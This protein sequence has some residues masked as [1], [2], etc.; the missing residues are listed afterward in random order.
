M[1]F[2]KMSK[3]SFKTIFNACHQI[4]FQK[5]SKMLILGPKNDQFPSF[6]A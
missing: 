4:Q 2:L 1:N 6:W 5:K 3:E